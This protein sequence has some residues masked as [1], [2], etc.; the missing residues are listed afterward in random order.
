MIDALLSE[1]REA[2]HHLAD[3]LRRE[4]SCRAGFLV[5][6]AAFDEAEA[7]RRLGYATL[8]DYLHREL[9][10]PRSSAHYRKV[11]AR[12]LRRFPEVVA[13]LR[14][15]RLCLSTVVELE[16]VLTEE[17]RASVL[18]RFF[19]L[20]RQEAKEIVAE[21]QPAEGIPR[22]T[23][24]TEVPVA[25]KLHFAPPREEASDDSSGELDLTQPERV[26]AQF[27]A[28]PRTTEPGRIVVD[29]MTVTESR[30]HVTVSRAFLV[31]LRRAKAGQSHVQPGATDEQVLTAGLELLIEKQE[32]RRAAVPPK[33][34]REVLKR[35]GG[36]CTWPLA[37][38][39]TCG[40]EVRLQIDHVVP[41]GKG[42]PSTTD[43]CR[44]LCQVH[45]L[46]AARQVY[47]DAHMDRFAPRNPVA[48]EPRAAYFAVRSASRATRPRR[49]TTATV[50][51]SP[52]HCRARS[53]GLAG[54]RPAIPS[55]L[56]NVAPAQAQA[57]VIG[58]IPASDAPANE[59]SPIR[60]ADST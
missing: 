24:V 37:D 26:E 52:T 56:P 8:F 45:N 23:V 1:A 7:F 57:K 34:K 14:D 11:A 31:L 4:N 19:G 38:G 58:A 20:S 44:I 49:I 46:E 16:K 5:A 29:P 41:R 10:L 53:P 55:R 27:G 22:R 13:P 33:V 12:L 3:L 6:L 40:S 28:P 59:G 17:N 9:L 47:G 2:S 36:K 25:S 43:N 60:L 50:A 21:L 54:G 18:P 51:P 35:D 30:L 42:G 39:G 32:K 15:G 48:E